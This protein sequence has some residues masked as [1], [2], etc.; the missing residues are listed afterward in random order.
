MPLFTIAHVLTVASNRALVKNP[1]S[2]S[3]PQRAP[4]A[5]RIAALIASMV[6]L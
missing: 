1:V 2:G 5:A 4:I 6:A 3:A